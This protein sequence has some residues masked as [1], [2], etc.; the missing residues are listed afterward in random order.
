MCSE[1]AVNVISEIQV[2]K[3]FLEADP[4]RRLMP[5]SLTQP[6]VLQLSATVGALTSTPL[7][8]MFKYFLRN[9]SVLSYFKTANHDRYDA[10]KVIN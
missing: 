8:Q 7:L 6:K 3:I 2:L 1:N 4:L 9:G 5:S 10:D